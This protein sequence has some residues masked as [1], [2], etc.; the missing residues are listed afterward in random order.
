MR[1]MRKRSVS[2][3]VRLAVALGL[4]VA[5]LIVAPVYAWFSFQRKA[6]EMYKIEYPNS[7]FINAAHR[8]DRIFFNL[9][10]ID[11]NDF[12][13]DPYTQKQVVDQDGNAVK[14][15]QM[16]Y[17]FSV[18]GSNTTTFRLQMAHTTNNLF[19]YTIYEA[20][21]FSD[22]NAAKVA[23]GNNTDLI[24]RYDTNLDS[25]SENTLQVIGDRYDDSD[26]GPL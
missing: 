13:L 25:H 3:K 17:A 1:R 21:Q 22:Y 2:K 10:G 5:V 6:A 16:M 4:T 9:G 7:L 20:K 15:T 24:V 8:E 26:A 19:Y 12:K 14:V 18:S 23:A 11:I